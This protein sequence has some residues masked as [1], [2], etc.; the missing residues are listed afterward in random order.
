MNMTPTS[1]SQII[2]ALCKRDGEQDGINIVGVGKIGA[3]LVADDIDQGN[4]VKHADE[5]DAEVKN[6]ALPHIFG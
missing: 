2:E 6:Y 4:F 1:V 3:P 5:L